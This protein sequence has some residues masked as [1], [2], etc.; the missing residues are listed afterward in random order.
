MSTATTHHGVVPPVRDGTT[1][2]PT[3]GFPV[4]PSRSPSSAPYGHSFFN[5]DSPRPG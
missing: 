5:S 4:A 1:R 2:A 3:S